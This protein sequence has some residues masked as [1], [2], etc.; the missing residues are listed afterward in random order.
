MNKTVKIRDKEFAIYIPSGRIEERIKEI[1]RQINEDL[2]GESPIF[3]SVLNGAFLF[4][5]D[6]IKQ[7]TIPCEVTFIRMSSY[8]GITSTGNMNQVLGL[9]ESIEGRVVVVVE[10]IVDTGNT[11]V[12]ILSELKKHRPAE[13][14]IASLLLKPK[15]LKHNIQVDYLGFE[16]PNNFLLGY[17]LDYNGFGRNL[18]DIYT[19]VS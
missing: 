13:I 5:A 3:I 7:I 10:D 16:V 12:S 8:E 4:T 17:G 18:N 6:L 2:D 9:K 1:G 14:K 11:V 15:A 19:L